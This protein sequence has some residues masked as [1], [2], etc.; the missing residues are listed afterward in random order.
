MHALGSQGHVD[1]VE[2][3]DSIMGTSGEYIP[4]LVHVISKIDRE[5]V[6]IMYLR[7]ETG[8]DNDWGESSDTAFDV[9]GESKDGDLRFGVEL[10]N[11]LPRPWASG[12]KPDEDLADNTDLT[13]TVRIIVRKRGA[14]VGCIQKQRT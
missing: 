13:G 8:I 12:V 6:Q 5:I 3:P 4:N 11:G 2:F 14:Y 7:R 9:M 1:I 10:F